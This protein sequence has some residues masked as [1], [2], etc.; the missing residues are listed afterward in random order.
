MKQG[1]KRLKFVHAQIN[2]YNGIFFE[3][4]LTQFFI[5]YNYI[6]YHLESIN[7]ISFLTQTYRVLLVYY[8]ARKADVSKGYWNPKRKLGETTQSFLR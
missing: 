2:L 6:S 3:Q 7:V 1:E 4:F 5:E 8:Y